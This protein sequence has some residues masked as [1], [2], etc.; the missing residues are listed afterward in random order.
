MVII[1]KNYHNKIIIYETIS[2]YLILSLLQVPI[3]AL[4]VDSEYAVNAVY[5]RFATD[6]AQIVLK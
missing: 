4:K 1:E 3:S 5:R 2:L 6:V